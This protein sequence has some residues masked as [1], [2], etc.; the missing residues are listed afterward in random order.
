MLDTELRERVLQGYYEKRREWR[1]GPLPSPGLPSELID[2]HGEP[3]IIRISQQLDEQG[4][5]DFEVTRNESGKPIHW[6]GEI[7]AK[8]VDY[9]EQEE[10]AP[11]E[12]NIQISDSQNIQVGNR[13]HQIVQSALREVVQRIEDESTSA[14]EKEE[15]KSKL[16]DF[17]SHPLVVSVVGDLATQIPEL[18][19]YLP[20]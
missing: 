6:T 11:T 10:E 5:I 14:A 18:Q 13:N 16:A 15:A 12:F 20:E 19:Q 7:T 3:E 9:V 8:G 2:E 1:S 17:L 4:L